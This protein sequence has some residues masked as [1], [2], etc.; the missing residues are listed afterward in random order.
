[1][2]PEQES[3]GPGPQ[4][5][6]DLLVVLQRAEDQH[7]HGGRGRVGDDP[8]GHLHAVE[9]GQRDVHDHDVGVKLGRQADGRLAVGRAPGHGEARRI[10]EQGMKTD[11]REIVAVGDHHADRA[12]PAGIA[13]VD[14]IDQSQVAHNATHYP[15]P[16]RHPAIPPCPRPSSR[17]PDVHVGITRPRR[18]VSGSPYLPAQP[19]VR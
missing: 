6:K 16:P 19:R 17:P 7:T 12:R 3:A 9:A 4:R 13:A 10:G 11:T 15:S 2:S 18:R 14:R 5:G 8:S 1:M